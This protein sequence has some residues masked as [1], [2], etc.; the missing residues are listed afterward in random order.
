[1]QHSGI[2]L[3]LLRIGRGVRQFELAAR[4]GISPQMLSVYESGRRTL[5]EGFSVRYIRALHM[6]LAE[7]RPSPGLKTI[8]RRIVDGQRE[9]D[10]HA[11]AVP[12]G[13]LS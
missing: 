11:H 13:R 3:K 9:F 6:L 5:P 4:L 8:R 7:P 10:S 1:M 2:M 12:T